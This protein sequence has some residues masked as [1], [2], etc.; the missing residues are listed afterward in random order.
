M[1]Q[2]YTHLYSRIKLAIL[3]CI[4][5]LVSCEDEPVPVTINSAIW[6]YATDK[7]NHG[8]NVEVIAIGPYGKENTIT[9]DVDGYFMISNLGNGTYELEYAKE[10]YGTCKQFGIQ[11]FGS[12]TVWTGRVELYERFD[13]LNM[14]VL[15]EIIDQRQLTGFSNTSIAITTNLIWNWEMPPTRVFIGKNDQVNSKNYLFSLNGFGLKRNGFE[16]QLIV[17]NDFYSLPVKSGQ[18]FYLAAYVCNYSDPG[19]LNPYTGVKTYPTVN[20]ESKS[21]VLTFIIP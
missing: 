10:E 15:Y 17:V 19:Y 11:L 20:K 8:I 5:L 16:R 13:S 6:G 9:E 7:W 21:E 3:T 2:K 14:P 18:T 12:D 1:K 4:L